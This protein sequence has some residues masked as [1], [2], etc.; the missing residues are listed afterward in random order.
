MLT[1]VLCITS[2]AN[3]V[4]LCKCL[5]LGLNHC[6]LIT[7]EKKVCHQLA[8]LGGWLLQCLCF[9][10]IVC[11]SGV[12]CLIVEVECWVCVCILVQCTMYV[13]FVCSFPCTCTT[14]SIQVCLSLY[15]WDQRVHKGEAQ[16]VNI[17]TKVVVWIQYGGLTGTF[18][19]WR[20]GWYLL[21][22]IRRAGR[23]LGGRK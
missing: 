21:F 4:D 8:I 6:C 10:G 2:V 7:I 9:V 16:R 23:G 1:Q 11:Q 5:Y 12:P 18:T 17:V 15:A 22:T 13:V 14:H 20:A 3:H 19:I